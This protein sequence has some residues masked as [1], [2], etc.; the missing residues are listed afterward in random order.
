MSLATSIARQFNVEAT[1]ERM[2]GRETDMAETEETPV[3]VATVRGAFRELG[4][5]EG[6]S[7]DRLTKIATHR[8]YCPVGTDVARGDRLTIAGV[9][10][11]VT[12]PVD[13]MLRGEFLQVDVKEP[14][15]V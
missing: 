10:Y 8:F 5:N 9:V 13:P 4:A 3:Q 12:N 6:L 15:H 2:I 1:I 11:L 7:A 14:S